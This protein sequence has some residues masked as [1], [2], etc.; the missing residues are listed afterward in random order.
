M[1]LFDTS[2]Q[3]LKYKVLREVASAAFEDRLE[4]GV[5]DIPALVV[6]GPKPTM[7]CCIYK[8]RAIVGDRIKLAMGGDPKNENVVEVLSIACD[9]CPVE[10]IQVSEAC[11]GCI[12]HRCVNVCPRNA[13]VV[14]NFRARV[15]KSKCIEC[16]RCVAACPYNAI[17]K[18]VRPCENACKVGA[19]HMDEG[20][21][22]CIDNG[23]CTGCGAC[24]YQCPF[25][26]ISD[27]SYILEAIRLLRGSDENRKYK[28]YA[29]V[30]P[31][32]S[33][34]FVRVKVEQVVS[35]LKRLGFFSVVEAALGADMVAYQE[36]AELAE[37]GFLTTSCCPAFVRYV[38][39]AFPELAKHISHNLSPM[40]EIS[41]YIKRLDPEAKVVFIGPCIAKKAERQLER[42]RDVV[43]C[44][45][46]FEELQ[47][48]FDSR[49]IDLAALPEEHLNN[50][51]YYGRIFARSGGVSTAVGQ[52]LKEQGLTDFDYKPIA[53]NG[54]LE[55]KMALLKAKK[56]VL[57]ANLIEGMACESGC[58]GGAACLT[59]GPKDK[60]EVDNYGK[61]ALEKTMTD[62]I[63]VYDAAPKPKSAH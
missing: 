28:V 51:S 20:K 13:I 10:G 56:G 3:E 33:S 8:E 15:D 29:V 27:K 42:V 38:Q 9:E 40:A 52:A 44:V 45:I 21:K 1:K 54:I 47:A 34:Q 12:A 43:D 16:G 46:T 55:C 63:S 35:G 4:R 36:A 19:I 62:A 5:L 39:T 41:A 18:T 25:G 7:R 32:I 6:P 61:Q 24:V 59:H 37:K 57:D 50:A 22:A 11:R 30:A 31:S 26:A 53:C 48:L 60:S 23:K 49:S 17:T 14:E 2:V 58:I